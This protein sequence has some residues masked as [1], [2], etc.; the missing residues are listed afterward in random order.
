MSASASI[1]P[2]ALCPLCQDTGWRHVT[3]DHGISEVQPCDCKHHRTRSNHWR[4]AC[5]PERYQHCELENFETQPPGRA[6]STAL[7]QA[8]GKARNF[9]ENY[10]LRGR[11]T[12][13]IFMGSCGA[14]K[15]HLAVGILRILIQDYGVEGRFADHR[16][17][18]K[19]IQATFDPLNPLSEAA[20]LE[21][22]LQ[23]ELLVMDDLGVGRSTEW[24][25]ETLHYLLNHRYAHNLT[26]I[27][28]TNLEEEP[29]RKPGMEAIADRSLTQMIG[30][31][32][33]SRLYEMCEPVEMRTEDFRR[34][35][36]AG[37]H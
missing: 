20:L 25:L 17:L 18:L 34:G 2:S 30:E 21:P 5:V 24:A 19:S 4:Q 29:A 7:F 36:L 37:G 32:L 15:T 3:G 23:S 31:R 14:G 1:P 10:T 9:V 11:R 27:I 6:P 8:L 28:T 16:E 22:L 33:R 26:T 13:L 12:G 35:M